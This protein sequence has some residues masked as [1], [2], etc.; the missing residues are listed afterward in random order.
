MSH[1][2]GSYALAFGMVI[3]VQLLW[4]GYQAV[5]WK[6]VQLPYAVS[7]LVLCWILSVSAF[8]VWAWL[9]PRFNWLG[10]LSLPLLVSALFG[11]FL[12]RYRRAGAASRP[13]SYVVWPDRLTRTTRV[14]LVL[15]AVLFMGT[16]AWSFFD[17]ESSRD[18]LRGMALAAIGGVFLYMSVRGKSVGWLRE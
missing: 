1:S 13:P 8:A 14:A 3:L 16:G 15:L 2:V 9:A 7:G 5:L 10:V 6:L 12:Y 4:E 18:V 17:V 11:T